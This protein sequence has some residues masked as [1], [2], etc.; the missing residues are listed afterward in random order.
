MP[1]LLHSSHCVIF[2]SEPSEIKL[3]NPYFNS[4]KGHFWKYQINLLELIFYVKTVNSYFSSSKLICPLILNLLGNFSLLKSICSLL[5][6]SCCCKPTPLFPACFA[7]V[8]PTGIT[9]EPSCI[10]ELLCF[11]T[12]SLSTYS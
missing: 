1:P 11:E 5:A 6:Y 3:L 10:C 9:L 4:L 2:K 8:P 12:V 7:C